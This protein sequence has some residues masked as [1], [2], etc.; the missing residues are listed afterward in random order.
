MPDSPMSGKGLA[1]FGSL[2]AGGAAADGAVAVGALAGGGAAEGAAVALAGAVAAGAFAAGG[3]AFSCARV[4]STSFSVTT[5][6]GFVVTMVADSRSPLRKSPILAGLPLR[7][8]VASR[9]S[10]S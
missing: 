6:G 3:A 9:L 8:R 10:A 7:Y 5:C 4:A 1:V 2:L